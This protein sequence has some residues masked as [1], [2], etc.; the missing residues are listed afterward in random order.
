MP[1][2]YFKV[3]LQYIEH[4][5]DEDWKDL[6]YFQVNKLLKEAEYVRL[7]SVEVKKKLTAISFELEKD[8][9]KS[10]ISL[11]NISILGTAPRSNFESG[12]NDLFLVLSKI[13]KLKRTASSNR[14]FKD[15]FELKLMEDLIVKKVEQCKKI[16]N[17]MGK[18][19]KEEDFRLAQ[20][21]KTELVKVE[22]EFH[23]IVQ[24]FS[25]NLSLLENTDFVSQWNR[26]YHQGDLQV[27][28]V[29]TSTNKE[30]QSFSVNPQVK[31][32][33]MKNEENSG[34]L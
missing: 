20:N 10:K 28:L 9:V 19:A 17:N 3:N 26:Y 4:S 34:A 18:A 14:K 31:G 11:R 24:S 6:G 23:Q 13:T 16:R 32:S 21:Y 33:P 2:E 22:D 27:E 15:A 29:Q 30:N 8:E 7:V 1:S 5:D 12:D 25:K